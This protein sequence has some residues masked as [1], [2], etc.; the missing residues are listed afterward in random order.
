MLPRI[1]SLFAMHVPQPIH[2]RTR[3]S[4]D[5]QRTYKVNRFNHFAGLYINFL[6]FFSWQQ[7]NNSTQPFVDAGSNIFSQWYLSCQNNL[8][9]SFRGSKNII[10]LSTHEK[11]RSCVLWEGSEISK[12]ENSQPNKI[13]FCSNFH[14]PSG[15]I[16]IIFW[17]QRH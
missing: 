4:W 9:E 11:N 5:L 14:K 13:H 2:T 1:W 15:L 12:I 7:K 17:N 8:F 6:R 10:F 16:W 3:A